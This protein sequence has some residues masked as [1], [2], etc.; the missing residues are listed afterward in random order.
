MALHEVHYSRS[1]ALSHRCCEFEERFERGARYEARRARKG[2]D[3][4]ADVEDNLRAAGCVFEQ[5]GEEGA[6][7]ALAKRVARAV[8][9]EEKLEG[10][11][12]RSRAEE[13]LAE[14]LRCKDAALYDL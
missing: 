10:A 5:A 2:G 7:G 11:N 14:P 1:S 6:R 12:E 8:A 4:L 9:S 3:E 13:L